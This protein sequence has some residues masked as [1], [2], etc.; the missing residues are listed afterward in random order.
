M[1]P[2]RYSRGI[3]IE[4]SQPLHPSST[5]TP[6]QQ[7]WPTVPPSARTT[8]AKNVGRVGI[9]PPPQAAP[10]R[11]PWYQL[12]RR[13]PESRSRLDLMPYTLTEPF[14]PGI[15]N[16]TPG[17]I[18]GPFGP[19][20]PRCCSCSAVDWTAGY[21]ALI[22]AWSSTQLRSEA[23]SQFVQQWRSLLRLRPS[24]SLQVMWLTVTV[25]GS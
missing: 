24:C 12:C 19:D 5:R 17:Y 20:A 15:S 13:F 18:P 7:A 11:M 23:S 6:W 9:T 22:C 8:I 16:L 3:P 25:P 1:Q 10:S 14:P 2:H 4:P 21:K